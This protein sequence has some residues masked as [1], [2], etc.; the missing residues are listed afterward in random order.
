M[1]KRRRTNG[2]GAVNQTKDGRWRATLDIGW[3]HGKR[4]REYLSAWRATRCN[5]GA[6]R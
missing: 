6:G 5:E 1:A 2:E 3:E 4:P